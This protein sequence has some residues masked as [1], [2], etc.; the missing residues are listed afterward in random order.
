MLHFPFHLALALM[1]EGTNQMLLV[2]HVMRDLTKLLKG[3][4]FDA[5]PQQLSQALKEKSSLIFSRFPPTQEAMEQVQEHIHALAHPAAN[6][7]QEEKETDAG[8]AFL[9]LVRTAVEGFGWEVPETDAQK[10]GHADFGEE[11]KQWGDGATEFF[12]LTFSKSFLL[13]LSLSMLQS[14]CISCQC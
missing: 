5:T 11:M 2:G 10:S 1:M 13:P 9:E 12:S 14:L 8:V 7:T 6:M 3:F 4:S